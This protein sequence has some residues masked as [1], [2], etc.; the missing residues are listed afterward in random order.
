MTNPID[1]I[2]MFSIFANNWSMQ[3]HGCA[4]TL[5]FLSRDPSQ[6]GFQLLVDST[7]IYDTPTEKVQTISHS[8]FSFQNTSNEFRNQ[9]ILFQTTTPLSESW[10]LIQSICP[11]G[12]SFFA[13]T[14]PV[15]T[16]IPGI[17]ASNT[18]QISNQDILT[19][20]TSYTWDV[21]QMIRLLP[22]SS[23]KVTFQTKLIKRKQSFQFVYGI[24]GNIGVTPVNLPGSTDTYFPVTQV[25]Q[26]Y[27]SDLLTLDFDQ[28]Q[29]TCANKGVYM[30]TYHTQPQLLIQTQ[31]I[32][33]PTIVQET[34]LSL[35][36]EERTPITPDSV[37]K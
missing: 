26:W 28:N 15:H 5:F 12:N 7:A 37:S 3:N 19:R 24:T 30:A 25:L 9:H 21:D 34:V 22:R 1:L 8:S 32:Q 27:Q 11:V 2:E 4:G 13:L 35:P 20:P 29:V 18:I 17:S 6:Q 31:S 10:E 16:D 14:I 36:L 33:N 23:T